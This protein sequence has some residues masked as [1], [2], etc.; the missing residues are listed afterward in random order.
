MKAM[1]TPKALFLST[2]AEVLDTKMRHL[3]ARFVYHPAM[4]TGAKMG[5]KAIILLTIFLILLVLSFGLI[6][7]HCIRSKR[8][9]RRK[10]KAEERELKHLFGQRSL[11]PREEWVKL[12]RRNRFWTY[13]ERRER[14]KRE[15]LDRKW[16]E[17]E[18]DGFGRPVGVEMPKR[19]RVRWRMW[20][21]D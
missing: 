5:L 13:R 10:K 16:E 2:G 20:N 7:W 8:R 17:M 1:H 3:T 14:E 11:Q 18:L 9:A 19:A 12:E 4:L 15:A 21:L 6:A